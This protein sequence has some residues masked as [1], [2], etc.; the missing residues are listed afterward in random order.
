MGNYYSL[1]FWGFFTI[2]TDI[3]RILGLIWYRSRG[4]RFRK[5]LQ[6][7]LVVLVLSL[8]DCTVSVLR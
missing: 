6:A 2:S 7:R 4:E 8:P 1:F 5:V 3:S